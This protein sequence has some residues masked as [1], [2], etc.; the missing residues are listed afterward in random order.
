MKWPFWVI[1]G[2]ILVVGATYL[3]WKNLKFSGADPSFAASYQR[4]FVNGCLDNA[5]QSLAAA[6]RTIDDALKERV[7]RVCDC[8]AQASIAEFQK[9]GGQS[10]AE[11]TAMM[12]DPA[13]KAKMGEIMQACRQQFGPL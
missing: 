3:G 1:G 13:F 4:S 6:G 12:S 7:A 5:T 11:M 10:M 8:G 2:L 9:D